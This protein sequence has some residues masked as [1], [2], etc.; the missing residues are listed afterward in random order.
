[1]GSV[2]IFILALVV[3]VTALYWIVLRSSAN[4]IAEQYRMLA[5]HFKLELNQPAAKMGG[6]LRPEPSVYGRYRGREL[7]IS[8]PGK[9]LQ[10]TRQVETVLKVGLRNPRLTAQLTASGPLANMRQ[11][12]SR[13]MKR[14]TAGD[15]TF[16]RAVDARTNDEAQLSKLLSDEHRTWLASSLKRSKATLYIGKE[17]LAFAK[18]GLINGATTRQQFEAAAEFLCDLA[19][20]I[21][22]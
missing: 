6:L 8:V 15:E 1:M 14:W 3:A 12:D 9:G 18:L 21:E 5:E 17:A 2:I 7:S 22:G 20:S 4:R 11:R 19:E 10:N 16:D 13:G